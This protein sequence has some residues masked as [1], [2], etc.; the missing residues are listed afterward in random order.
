M[1]SQGPAKRQSQAQGGQAALGSELWGRGAQKGLV[2]PWTVTM[3]LRVAMVVFFT[4]HSYVAVSDTCRFERV[5]EASYW[6]GSEAAKRTLCC[7]WG[8]LPWL[9]LLSW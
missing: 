5:M 2:I 6:L 3:T 8:R 7:R 9:I 4:R 1:V